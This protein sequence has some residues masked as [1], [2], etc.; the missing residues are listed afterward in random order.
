MSLRGWALGLCL[1]PLPLVLEVEGVFSL[2]P[3]P[4]AHHRAFP[5]TVDPLWNHKPKYVLLSIHSFW[6]WRLITA[7]ESALLS[8]PY[9]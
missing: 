9:D 7:T 5:A 3:A 4:A 8:L 1:N 2:L 6:S